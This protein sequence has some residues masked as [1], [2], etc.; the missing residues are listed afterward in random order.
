M[1]GV[2]KLPKALKLAPSFF[3]TVPGPRRIHTLEVWNDILTTSDENK[4][5]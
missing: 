5:S 4:N 1:G 2:L 3:L